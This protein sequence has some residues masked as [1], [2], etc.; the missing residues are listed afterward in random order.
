MDLSLAYA[1][2]PLSEASQ[3]Y[4]VIATHRGLYAFQRLLF[5]VASAP[6]IWQKTMDE[7]LQGIP[8]VVCF[9][10]DVLVSGANQK[11]HDA[12]L[13]KVL[14]RLAKYGVWLAKYGVRLR[15][16]KCKMSVNQVRY[17]GFTISGS[18]LQTND[19]KIKAIVKA[20]APT[21]LSTLQSF[22]VL[23]TFYS[24]FV[25]GC[26]D[27][28]HPLRRLLGKEVPWEWSEEC[29]QAFE[30]IKFKLSTAPVLAHFDVTRTVIVECDAS[31]QGLGA[32]LLHEYSDGSRRP[33]CYVSRAF[34]C[35]SSLQPN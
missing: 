31:P 17:L 32:C 15:R 3:K 30:K 22:L 12:R 27:C 18:G 24:R 33:V 10:D 28:L 5:G 26:S 29:A 35:R 21:D 7:I 8:G 6:A 2:L 34:F 9:Y 11:E 4:C 16:E 13:R 23:V 20:P 19:D 14:I 1:Q 25:Q